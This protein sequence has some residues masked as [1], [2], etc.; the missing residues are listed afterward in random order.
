RNARISLDTPAPADPF[1]APVK[2]VRELF[3]FDSEASVF[4]RVRVRGQV[5][6]ADAKRIF[7][8]D[9]GSGV[10]IL[11]AEGH[12]LIAGALIEAVGYPEVSGPSPG[13][14]EASVRKMGSAPLPQPP[15]VTAF[16][17][18][19]QKLDARRL[20]VDARLVGLHSEQ[21]PRVLKMQSSNRLFFAR[22]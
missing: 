5:V 22:L 6:H 1:D 14:R 12:S 8:V 17:L 15:E 2:S 7:A 20:R 21:D 9:S 19:E 3:L 10:R 4:Q 11:P 13:L 16:D 18:P